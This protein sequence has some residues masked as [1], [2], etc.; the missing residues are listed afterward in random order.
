MTTLQI[1]IM[2]R[3]CLFMMILTQIISLKVEFKPQTH[4]CVLGYINQKQREKQNWDY[5]N[6]DFL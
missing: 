5:L 2:L 3:H 1:I 4:C 6:L